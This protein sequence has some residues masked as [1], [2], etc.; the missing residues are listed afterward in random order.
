MEG[1]ISKVDLKKTLNIREAELVDLVEKGIL[2][3]YL[4]KPDG[5]FQQIFRVHYQRPVQRMDATDR[6][7]TTKKTFYRR[8]TKAEIAHMLKQAVWFRRADLED[9]HYEGKISFPESA[10]TTLS[11]AGQKG[12]KTPKKNRAITEA[13]K[14]FLNTD[15]KTLDA[16]DDKIIK[17]FARKFI[18]NTPCSFKLDGK[19]CEVYCDGEKVHSSIGSKAKKSI[20][21]STVKR[22][23]LPAVK[24]TI[25]QKK[26]N[27]PS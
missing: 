22:S 16:H 15:S 26:S 14:I 19:P 9:A 20:K 4:Q 1:Y 21:L 13:I 8:P 11:A 3:I 23:Y 10:V 27:N 2:P 12:G 18:S 24:K 25:L 17:R 5:T 6:P 7:Y